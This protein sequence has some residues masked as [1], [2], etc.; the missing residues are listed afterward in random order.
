ML[1]KLFQ[2]SDVALTRVPMVLVVLAAC[3][4]AGCSTAPARTASER[5]ADRDIANRV[6]AAL[7]ADPNIYARH[8][9]VEVDR[10]VVHLG[11]YVWEVDDFATARRDAASV[12][13][14]TAVVTD[15]E[16]M[17]GGMAGTG[18]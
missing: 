11:G 1:N 9:D 12:P 3:T 5:A 14:T 8:I 7:L 15:M 13:G 6:Q 4:L 16:L 10:G 2:S 18:R 17:R